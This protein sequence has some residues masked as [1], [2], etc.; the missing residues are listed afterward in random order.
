VPVLCELAFQCLFDGDDETM[1]VYGDCEET[2]DKG[3]G[4]TKIRE[5]WTSSEP[6]YLEYLASFGDWEGLKPIAMSQ[7]ERYTSAGSEVRRAFY[8]FCA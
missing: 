4:R 8:A 3:N 7:V 2:V 6:D 5:C 1:W